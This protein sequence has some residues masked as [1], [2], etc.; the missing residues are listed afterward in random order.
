VFLEAAVAIRFSQPLRDRKRILLI[1]RSPFAR[2]SPA[3]KR[4]I[5]FGDHGALGRRT[6]AVERPN[7]DAVFKPFKVR[8]PVERV[9]SF[10][11][12][13]RDAFLLLGDGSRSAADYFMRGTIAEVPH[14]RSR[15]SMSSKLREV[16]SAREQSGKTVRRSPNTHE[17]FSAAPASESPW[18]PTSRRG[19]G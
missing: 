10:A 19:S 9:S 14:G 11:H 1:L 12:F 3:P 6:P 13:Y 7:M 18:R 17:S 2:E 5:N 8:R 4:G 15:S 16:R